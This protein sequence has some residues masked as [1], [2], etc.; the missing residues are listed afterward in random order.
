MPTKQDIAVPARHATT[1]RRL[2]FVLTAF[3]LIYVPFSKIS[4]YVYWFF[5]RVLMG[6]KY[7]RRGVMPRTGGAQ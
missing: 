5:A 7:G 3:F 2:V 4:H 6:V 1:A